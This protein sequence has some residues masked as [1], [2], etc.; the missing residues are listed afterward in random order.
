MKKKIYQNFEKRPNDG[1]G[2]HI[3]FS[4]LLISFLLFGQFCATCQERK[5]N[6]VLIISDQ[7]Q[8]QALGCNGAVIKDVHG[9]SPTPNIDALAANG[10]RFANAYTAS[11]L[12]AP[13][14]A[15]LMTGVY[16]HQHTAL[17]HKYNNT[18]PGH[19]RFPGILPGLPTIG[20]VFREQ[21]YKTAAI[22]KMHVHGEMKDENDL[23]FDVIDMRFYTWYPGAHY[24]DRAE[25]DWYKRYRELPPYDQMS[26]YAIDSVKFSNVPKHL[27]V[28][29]NS[30]QNK[31][32]IE[33]IVEKETQIMDFITA[34]SSISFIQ[35]CAAQNQ[36]FFIHIGFEKPHE[37]YNAPKRFM[38]LFNPEEMILPEGWHEV[39]ERGPYPYIMNWLV[40]YEPE[41][42]TARNI[43]AS[44][45]AA[46]SE[47]DE[48]V[49]RVIQACK[50][51]GIYENTI[52]IYTSDHGENMYNHSLL[53]K[54]C[55]FETSVKI[56]LILSYSKELPQKQACKSLVS[57]LDILP[58][59]IELANLEQP[60]TFIGTSL[61]KA[62]SGSS[63]AERC[64]FAEFHEGNGNYKMFPQASTI[65]M[66]MCRYKNYKYVYTHGFIEQLY[67]LD[68]DPGELNNLALSNSEQFETIIQKL[69]AETLNGW[70]VDSFPLLNA[71][72]VVLD[73]QV[74]LQ[75]DN[76]MC[77]NEYLVYK[78]IN[79]NLEN[80]KLIGRTSNP[81]FID[82]SIS[83]GKTN[84]YW[85]IGKL[86][87]TRET[88]ESNYYKNIPVA[89]DV[90][91]N[92]LPATMMMTVPLEVGRS[93]EF[94]YTN[95]GV[96]R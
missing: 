90:L 76:T 11:P 53:Q 12:C 46:V 89:T 57:S 44:Y 23:G 32:H 37:P 92:H 86:R 95:R 25:G 78:G 96:Y 75:W 27:T 15:S 55:M 16:P 29:E 6:V 85:I 40:S 9:N 79:E 49:G 48:Q 35:S 80:A 10:I 60:S 13:T 58:T 20:Q 38:D 42:K 70:T 73:N 18:E 82:Y 45:Y 36:P 41:E 1:L 4:I 21:G 50:D 3:C 83:N 84:Y 93:F 66:R 5:P 2:L 72:V 81:S 43:M 91:P 51:A 22:G 39:D 7:H 69:R 67:D 94:N 56:P 87:L 61:V 88:E 64:V 34:D 77:I 68:S 63:D 14:R 19:T 31:Y 71:K 54:H 65:P 47:M 8:Y 52:F 59:I 30:S 28:K 24:S 33:T 74:Q 17:H 26:Y 62:I